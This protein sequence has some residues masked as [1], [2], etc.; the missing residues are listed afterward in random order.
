MGKGLILDSNMRRKL[1]RA[2]PT[3]LEF[4]QQRLPPL[5]RNSNPPTAIHFQ[6]FILDRFFLHPSTLPGFYRYEQ[7]CSACFQLPTS[8]SEKTQGFRSNRLYN[9]KRFCCKDWDANQEAC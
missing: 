7:R 5:Q 3:P 9:V 4:I 1:H 6:Q 2:H 8:R